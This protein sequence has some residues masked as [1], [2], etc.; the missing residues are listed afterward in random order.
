MSAPSWPEQRSEGYRSARGLA[1]A[2][3]LSVLMFG[4][5]L[6]LIVL[7]WPASAAEP[8]TTF[9]ASA[10]ELVITYG[11]GADSIDV[12]V[13]YPDGTGFNHHPN[14]PAAVGEV[15]TL[16]LT[17]LPAWV[18]VHSTDCHIGEPGSPGHGTDCR[19]IEEGP[20][21]TPTPTTPTGPTAPPVEPSPEPTVEPTEDPS[22]TPTGA[23]SPSTPA[24]SPSATTGPSPAASA[25][26]APGAP[27]AT[28]YLSEVSAVEERAATASP[29][30]LAATGT[31]AGWIAVGALSLIALGAVFVAARKEHGR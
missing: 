13:R 19:L 20:W 25:D 30:E 14:R 26:P 18:Q 17:G 16:P 12:N 3:W 5:L 23:P 6:G 9:T 11:A 8:R 4:A 24:P 28:E 2:A 29:R 1:V 27:S 10:T 15:L 7:A 31:T 22:P 21:P